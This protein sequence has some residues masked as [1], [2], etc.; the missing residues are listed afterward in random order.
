P[1]PAGHERSA[2]DARKDLGDGESA[3]RDHCV[4]HDTHGQQIEEMSHAL[5]ILEAVLVDRSLNWWFSVVLDRTHEGA[6]VGHVAPNEALRPV[7]T[8]SR[9]EMLSVCAA[10]PT[11]LGVEFLGAMRRKRSELGGEVGVAFE[12]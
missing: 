1:E 6:A 7:T 11:L 10:E 5:V 2:S 3:A 8:V 12:V 4:R 9:T